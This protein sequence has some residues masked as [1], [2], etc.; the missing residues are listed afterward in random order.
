MSVTIT[1]QAAAVFKH[2]RL[3]NIYLITFP[4]YVHFYSR[5]SSG[6]VSTR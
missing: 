1:V 5:I 3:C 2:V 6:R 4:F